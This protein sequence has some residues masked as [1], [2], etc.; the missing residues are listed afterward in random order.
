MLLLHKNLFHR[1]RSKPLGTFELVAIALGG[2]VG[3]GI[4]TVLGISVALIGA[5]TPIAI[6][7]GGLMAMLAA[8]SYVKLGVYYLDEGATYSFYKRTFSGSPFSASLI[9]WYVTFGYI[10]TIALYAY[11]F[12]SYAISGSSFAENQMARMGVAAAVI[13]VFALLN[14]WSVKGMGKIE[15]LM[16]YSKLIILV[17]ISFV[18]INNSNH[19]LPELLDPSTQT[20]A[21]HV[22]MVAALTFVAFEGFQLVIH[23][24]NEMDKPAQNIPRAIYTAVVV[25]T[26]IY[27]AIA[28]G[29]ILS[30]PFENIIK[31]KEYALA[32]SANAQL[33]NWGTDLIIIGALLATSSA[34]NGTLFGASRLMSVIAQDGFFPPLLARRKN[35]IPVPA[36][37]IMALLAI[38]MLMFDGLELIL[39]FASITFLLVSALMA[40]ANFKIRERTQSSTALTLLAVGA[41]SASTLLILYYEYTHKPQ[42]LVLIIGIYAAL[43]LGAW[44]YSRLHRK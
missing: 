10:S 38:V 8:Y 44:L 36:I 9:G 1:H 23:A 41:L 5:L 12:S 32:A 7:I 25:A 39:E 40:Y 27:M 3:G 30:I 22:L 17:V 35:H 20:P 24:M 16:V 43:T 33:G 29:A 34:I 18:L 2:M 11:T 21:L 19:S 14:L 13:M 15:D 26:L 28:L 4:F 37:L 31:N 6:F 42:E